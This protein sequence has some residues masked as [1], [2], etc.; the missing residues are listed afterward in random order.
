MIR[1]RLHLRTPLLVLGT[2]TLTLLLALILVW[3]GAM[4]VLLAAKVAPHT[5]NSLSAYRSVYDF[6]AKLRPSDFSTHR[7]LAAGFGGAIAFVLLVYLALQE[8]PRP[9]LAR[10]RTP[11][12]QSEGG[13]LTI[14]P[15]VLERLAEIAASASKD[16]S[17]ASG[18]LG[19]GTLS[20]N[21]GV[22]RARSVAET[23]VEV[24][25]RVTAELCRHEVLGL[26]VDVT[27]TKFEPTTGRNLS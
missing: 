14:A 16:V 20:L 26:A 13:S 25:E 15:R 5:V 27:V 10:A 9:Y 3:Y 22:R 19:E 4:L 6:L 2:R 7:R 24:R 1:T 12:M 17:G 8:L 21:I 23:L 18:R 11:S